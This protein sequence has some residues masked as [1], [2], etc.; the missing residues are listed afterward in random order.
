MELWKNYLMESGIS[1]RGL[2]PL[3]IERGVNMDLYNYLKI[4]QRDFDVYDDVY[5]ACVTVCYIDDE[6]VTDNYDKFCTE[7]IKK[8]DVIK[9]T[10]D[11][12]LIA[13]WTKLI[14]DNM[15]QFKAFTKEHWRYQYEDDEDEF[16]YQWI[17]EINLYMAG[18]VSEN[19]YK[20]LCD[21]VE[22]L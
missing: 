11:C 14:K 7:I 10:D 15:A 1:K 22:L 16:I 4:A 20:K 21:F 2:S 13:N 12:I 19:F 17:N 9:Q 6:D 8:V 18:Y 5:D 3:H